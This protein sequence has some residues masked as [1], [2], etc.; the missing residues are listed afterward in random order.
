[1]TINSDSRRAVTAQMEAF[2]HWGRIPKTTPIKPVK[3]VRSASE[4]PKSTPC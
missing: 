2:H 1:M 3:R 4:R